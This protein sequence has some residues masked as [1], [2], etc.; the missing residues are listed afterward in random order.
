VRPPAPGQHWRYR[1]SDGLSGKPLGV[2]RESVAAVGGDVVIERLLE[3]SAPGPA[4]AATS[5]Q[6]II[7]QYGN[8]PPPA[9][10]LPPE[11]QRPWGLLEMDPHWDLPQ[12]Y[13]EPV[14]AWPAELR[15]GWRRFVNT[16]YT[17]RA[18][19]AALSWQQTTRAEAW[20]QVTV[21]AGSFTALRYSQQ[22]VFTHTDW[23]RIHCSREETL[24]L[25]PEV[26][27]WVRR[28][29]RGSYYV[30]DTIDT[31]PY[32]EEPRNWELMEWS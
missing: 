32:D 4:E 18:G 2:V 30:N 3:G 29:S 9:Q 11:V 16:R 27:R 22:I 25:A 13:L 8:R 19:A 7:E 23:A 20:E 6:A 24:W 10:T 12:I 14:P 26:G 1:T 17:V 31:T 5:G 21:P 28:T 15:P